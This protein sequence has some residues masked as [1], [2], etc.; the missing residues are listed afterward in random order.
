MYGAELF[1]QNKRFE[2]NEIPLDIVDISEQTVN[3][4]E[5]KTKKQLQKKVNK[6]S[7]WFSTSKS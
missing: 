6:K 5:N 2:I 7:E 3:K 4:I 1:K